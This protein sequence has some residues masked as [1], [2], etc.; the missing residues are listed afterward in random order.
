MKKKD[1]DIGFYE[2]AMDLAYTGMLILIG[3]FIVCFVAGL[4][5]GF[6]FFF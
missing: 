1:D 4:V 5:F 6:L 3:L 2:W